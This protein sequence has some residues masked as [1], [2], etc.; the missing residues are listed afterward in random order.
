MIDT[1]LVCFKLRKKRSEKKIPPLTN[2]PLE[3]AEE[4][5]ALAG[6]M[7]DLAFWDT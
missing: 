4:K 5:E 6:V 1:H 3:N 7:Q 2:L